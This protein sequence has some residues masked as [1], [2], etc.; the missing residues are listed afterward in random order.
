MNNVSKITCCPV[1]SFRVRETFSLRPPNWQPGLG[2]VV[3]DR[4]G[5]SWEE[6]DLPRVTDLKHK[7]LVERL[8]DS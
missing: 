2:Y 3:C 6:K 7:E 5:C 1:C 4:P 8:A